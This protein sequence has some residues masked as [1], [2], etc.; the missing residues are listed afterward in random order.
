MQV[1]IPIE[2]N[3]DEKLVVAPGFHATDVLCIYNLETEQY[4]EVNS[5]ELYKHIGNITSELLKQ[6]I[7]TVITDEMSFMALSV[8]LGGGLTVYKSDGKD[9]LH[10]IEMLKQNKLILYS[11]LLAYRSQNCSSSCNSCN[12]VCNN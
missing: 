9:L 10:N 1:L 11:T 6:D 3:K 4:T 12:T 7:H 8:F 5:G 2:K